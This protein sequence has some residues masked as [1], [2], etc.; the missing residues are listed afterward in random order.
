M[1]EQLDQYLRQSVEQPSTLATPEGNCYSFIDSTANVL[2]SKTT[3]SKFRFR[4]ATLLRIREVA[5]D[6]CRLEL[7]EVER[8]DAKLQNQ[9][10]QISREQNS[11]AMRAPRG[12]RA[13]H[14]RYSASRRSPSVRLGV[15]RAKQPISGSK[16]ETLATEIDRCAALI[17]SIGRCERWRNFARSSWQAYRQEED[18]QESKRL[19][20]G[21]LADSRTW[22]VP[23]KS[24]V[25]K[26]GSLWQV[27]TRWN[28]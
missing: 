18:R 12:R 2:A 16:R 6:Q 1:Q 3:M 7:A 15:C 19:D 8:A 9:L 14:G 13:G 26:N 10:A 22:S 24:D 4:L 17:E 20:E 28:C 25:A 23:R 11:V 5:R 27:N 21:G